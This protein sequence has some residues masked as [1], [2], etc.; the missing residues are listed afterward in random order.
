MW[1]WVNSGR[2]RWTGSL[3]MLQFMGS[4]R[5]GHDWA[6]ELN[7]IDDPTRTNRH[8]Q[9]ILNC[10]VNIHV[11]KEVIHLSNKQMKWCSIILATVR[12]HATHTRMPK[13][14]KDRITSVSKKVEELELFIAGRNVKCFSHF[15]KWPGSYSNG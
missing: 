4:Q 1:V 2:W 12:I 6:T 7:W 8:L 14:K 9:N 10:Y 15:V 3:E 5:V 11:Y 13:I